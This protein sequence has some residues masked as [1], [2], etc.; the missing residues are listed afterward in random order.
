[1]KSE[2]LRP[3][4]NL[5]GPNIWPGQRPGKWPVNWPEKIMLLRHGQSAGNVA[6][7]AAELSDSSVIDIAMRDVDVPLSDL[8]ERQAAA[9]GDWLD[10]QPEDD[11]P[12]VVLTSPYLRAR[13]TAAIALSRLSP[14]NKIEVIFDERLREREFGIVDRLTKKGILE[15]FPEQAELHSRLKKFYYRAPGGESWCD[16]ILRLRS[17]QDSL[18]RDYSDERVLIVCH[19]VVVLCFRYLFEKMTEEQILE[20]DRGNQLANCSLTSYIADKSESAQKLTL[21]KFNFVVPLIEAGEK[22]TSKPD[23]PAGPK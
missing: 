6:L 14:G 1:M 16:V 20:V 22:V 15:K 13:E 7:E 8:G 2:S 9:F 3:Q 18:A 11:K 4:P 21:D 5:Q 17:V 19:T 10:S 23:V 12:T